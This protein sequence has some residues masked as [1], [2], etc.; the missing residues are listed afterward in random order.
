[1]IN[2]RQWMFSHIQVHPGVEALHGPVACLQPGEAVYED[3]AQGRVNVLRGELAPVRPVVS[4]GAPV[5]HNLRK[6]LFKY[7]FYDFRLSL[8][9]SVA[10]FW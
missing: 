1:M 6:I 7:F 4:P 2:I 9:R 10:S 8:A 5:A 3:G